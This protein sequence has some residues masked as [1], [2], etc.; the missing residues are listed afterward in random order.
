VPLNAIRRERCCR[1]ACPVAEKKLTGGESLA[2]R[3]ELLAAEPQPWGP[4]WDF[5]NGVDLF[6]RSGRISPNQ[7]WMGAS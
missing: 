6:A 2:V 3:F 4:V 7:V 5:E 1:P